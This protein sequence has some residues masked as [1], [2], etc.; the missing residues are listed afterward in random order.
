MTSDP[1]DG[2][3]A[4]PIIQLACLLVLLHSSQ[5]CRY[6]MYILFEFSVFYSILI[7]GHWILEVNPLLIKLLSFVFNGTNFSKL[8][9]NT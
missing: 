2:D 3:N 5:A 1:A 8:N 6:H 9:G 4:L 7:P